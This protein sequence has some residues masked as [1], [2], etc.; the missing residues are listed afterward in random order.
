VSVESPEPVASEFCDF[1]ELLEFWDL[2]DE[3][4]EEVPDLVGTARR[5]VM[6]VALRGSC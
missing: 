4:A 1:F 3:V 2:L 5:W 6:R